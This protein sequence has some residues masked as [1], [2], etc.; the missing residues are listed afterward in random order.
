M[1]LGLIIGLGSA[2]IAG[3]SAYSGYQT[4]KAARRQERAAKAQAKAGLLMAQE[5]CSNR[6]DALGRRLMC[7]GKYIS[8]S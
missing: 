2:A 4:S 6:A 1:A 5:S 3:A 8:N 7:Y